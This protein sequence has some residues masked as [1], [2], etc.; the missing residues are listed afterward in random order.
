VGDERKLS[1]PQLSVIVAVLAMLAMHVTVDDII[2]VPGMRDRDVFATDA[3]L[4]IAR[5]R[6]A[7][8]AGIAGRHVV[9]SE[10]V[11]VDVIAVRMV[12][13]PVVHVIHVV[14]MANGEMAARGT[15]KV[16]VAI[17]NVRFHV[18]TSTRDIQ[19]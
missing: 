16:I 19:V 9:L 10:L 8:V 3:V 13:V 14:L 2:D 7:R 18:R 5:M 1:E 15:V 4:V 6:I 12:E 11:F 17:V